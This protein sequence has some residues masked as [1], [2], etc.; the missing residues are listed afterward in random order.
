M[1]QSHNLTKDASLKNIAM[2]NQLTKIVN[3]LEK[4]PHWLCYLLLNYLLGLKVKFVGTAKVRCLHLSA[5]KAVFK[6]ANRRKVRNHIGTIHAAATALVAETATGMALAMHLPDDKLPLLKS[7]HIDYLS[8]TKGDLIAESSLT[9]EQ[10]ELLHTNEKGN[11]LI[12]CR[13]IDDS[14]LEPVSCQMEWAWTTRNR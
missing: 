10:I 4:L 12:A 7:M 3:K 14:R 13:I 2:K 9:A 11:L 5:D 1:R 6:L 8:R